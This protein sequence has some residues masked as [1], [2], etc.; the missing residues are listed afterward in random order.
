[1]LQ[2]HFLDSHRRHQGLFEKWHRG[3]SIP[4]HLGVKWCAKCMEVF[5]W[6][7]GSNIFVSA[8]QKNQKNYGGGFFL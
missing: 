7:R 8:P 5:F 2:A 4:L 6:D 3:H 1:M